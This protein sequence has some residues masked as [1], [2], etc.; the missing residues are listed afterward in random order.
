[1][2]SEVTA[3]IGSTSGGLSSFGSLLFPFLRLETEI[4]GVDEIV[5]VIGGERVIDFDIVV[6]FDGVIVFDTVFKGVLDFDVVLES[7]Q[8]I[9]NT[10][11]EFEGTVVSLALF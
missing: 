6:D 7:P 11:G 1:M 5:T 2:T 8:S 4:V 3:R 10:V 9:T